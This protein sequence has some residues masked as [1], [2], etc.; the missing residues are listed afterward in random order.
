MGHTIWLFIS[1]A[2]DGIF[3]ASYNFILY[4]L[5][6]WHSALTIVNFG[7]NT[8]EKIGVLYFDE[9]VVHIISRCFISASSLEDKN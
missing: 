6:I 3:V 7:E 1:L 9:C 4:S 2:T 5:C 8:Y